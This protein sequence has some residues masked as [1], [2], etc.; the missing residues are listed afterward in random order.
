MSLQARHN[1][2]TAASFFPTHVN[3]PDE[4]YWFKIVQVLKYLKG[5]R[6]LKLKLWVY[7]LC[8]VKCWV[9]ASYAVQEDCKGHTGAMISLGKGDVKILQGGKISKVRATWIMI[10]SVH[11]IHCRKCFDTN[12]LLK[13]KATP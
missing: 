4:Y 3:H 6:G 1:I 2:Q 8:I 13:L 9:C 7:Y 10:L 5:N 12:I 11:I